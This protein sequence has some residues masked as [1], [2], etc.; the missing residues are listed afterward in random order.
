MGHPVAKNDGATSTLHHV[1]EIK[2]VNVAYTFVRNGGATLLNAHMGE[3]V[4][5]NSADS[6]VRNGVATSARL[7][8]DVL[9]YADIVLAS[10]RKL[11]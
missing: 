3:M 4:P 11:Q 5:A 1:H 9:P 2:L 10:A 7:R 6:F 8:K